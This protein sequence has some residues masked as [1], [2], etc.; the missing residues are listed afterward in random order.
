MLTVNIGAMG[1]TKLDS[2]ITDSTIWQAPDA[3]RLVWITLL[4]MADQNGYIGASVPGLAG[5]ARV[6]LDDCILALEAFIAPD[7]WSRTK[8]HEGRRIA[9]A[10]G[11]WVLLNHAK[12]RAAQNVEDRRERS[13][14]AMAELRNKRKQ[15]LTVSDGYHSLPELPQA[16]AEADTKAREEDSTV[17]ALPAPSPPPGFDGENAKSIAPMALVAFVKTWELPEEWGVDA[18]ALGFPRGDVL[19]EAEKFRQYWFAGK[20]AGKRKT[21]K[22]W[23]QSWSNWLSKAAERRAA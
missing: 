13:R 6:Q 4:S 9:E 16:E 22:G 7:K 21:L 17:A 12:Y 20:G 8:D 3:T 5:R 19:R 1:Y 10:D 15:T 18:E 2:G 14:I 23:R 11:G